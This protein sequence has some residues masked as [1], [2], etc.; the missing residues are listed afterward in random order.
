MYNAA[1]MFLTADQFRLIQSQVKTII[2]KLKQKEV[3]MLKCIKTKISTIWRSLKLQQVLYFDQQTGL[4]KVTNPA[5]LQTLVRLL[6]R[7]QSL[8]FDIRTLAI[9]PDILSTV[10]TYLGS[11]CYIEQLE[12]ISYFYNSLSKQVK[13]YQKPLLMKSAAFYEQELRKC[14][15]ATQMT[16][17]STK[18]KDTQYMAKLKKVT[19]YAQNITN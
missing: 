14:C 7:L 18:I 1:Q 10:E 5:Q 12:N 4:L 3:E 15:Q 9:A 2:D 11:K 17:S 16:I 13:N 19:D 6:T 8:G